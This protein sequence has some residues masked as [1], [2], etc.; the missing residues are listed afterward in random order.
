MY[1]AYRLQLHRVHPAVHVGHRTVTFAIFIS[2][3]LRAEVPR[4]SSRDFERER[5]R[6]GEKYFALNILI[7]YLLYIFADF[8]PK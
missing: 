6:D 2:I 4:L 7:K 8:K 3:D 1:P 5:E